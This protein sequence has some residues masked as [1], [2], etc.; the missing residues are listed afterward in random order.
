MPVP[1]CQQHLILMI[2]RNLTGITVI[3]VGVQLALCDL[4]VLLR[5][6]LVEG[7]GSSGKN[8]AGVAV[9]EDLSKSMVIGR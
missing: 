5:D 6:D 7:I 2:S 1:G 3:G 4:N 9:A 8:L